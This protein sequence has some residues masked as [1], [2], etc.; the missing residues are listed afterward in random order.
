MVR[1]RRQKAAV[2][3]S[4]INVKINEHNE[5]EFMEVDEADF[6][7]DEEN[8]VDRLDIEAD[9]VNDEED[10]DDF[11]DEEELIPNEDGTMSIKMSPGNRKK[12]QVVEH[13]C[14]K[15]S[16]TYAT[17]RVNFWRDFSYFL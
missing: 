6:D 9:E 12:K 3:T 5:I 4:V 13:V 16:K 8:E 10:D 2:N 7:E 15:C 14:A 17:L 11:E 1:P